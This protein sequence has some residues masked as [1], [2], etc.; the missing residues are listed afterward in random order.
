MVV[1]YVLAG[2][3]VDTPG[4]LS[5]PPPLPP[6]PVSRNECLYLKAIAEG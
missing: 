1:V 5:R 6:D 3:V 2:V 4:L